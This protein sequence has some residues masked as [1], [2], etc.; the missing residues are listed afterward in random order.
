[1]IQFYHLTL[2][3]IFKR[4]PPFFHSNDRGQKGNLSN[5]QESL[6]LF[7]SREYCHLEL[8]N[9]NR[10]LELE[11]RSIECRVETWD[12]CNDIET[13]FAGH[14]VSNKPLD[15]CSKFPL[16]LRYPRPY[17]NCQLTSQKLPLFKNRRKIFFQTTKISFYNVNTF[18]KCSKSSKLR[19]IIF[20]FKFCLFFVFNRIQQIFNC[21]PAIL[22]NLTMWPRIKEI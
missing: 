18:T 16:R 2:V 13:S 4:P 11:R 21:F 6:F 14:F 10:S 17:I 1:M 12:L 9:G 20:L 7:S 3:T 8:Y 19:L 15:S 5:G 22:L